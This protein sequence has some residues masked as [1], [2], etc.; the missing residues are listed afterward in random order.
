MN[1]Q[2]FY[3]LLIA[4]LLLSNI[5]LAVMLFMHHPPGPLKNRHTIIDRLHFDAHQTKRYDALIL[6]HQ[7]QWRL[8]EDSMQG[9]RNQLYS[10]LSDH[11]SLVSAKEMNHIAEMVYQMEQLHYGHFR[12]IHSLC[13]PEQEKDFQALTK[14]LASMFSH[15]MKKK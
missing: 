10:H 5:L 11:D 14:D 13:K 12:Q 7:K 8:K 9:Y 2:K 6:E 4:I 1:K 15:H 3:L